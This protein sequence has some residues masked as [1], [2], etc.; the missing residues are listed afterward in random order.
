MFT[1]DPIP[2]KMIHMD[3][4]ILK[5]IVAAVLLSVTAGVVNAAASDDHVVFDSLTMVSKEYTASLTRL[6]GATFPELKIEI[7]WCKDPSSDDPNSETTVYLPNYFAQVPFQSGGFSFDQQP[8]VVQAKRMTGTWNATDSTVTF[9]LPW[10]IGR[11]SFGSGHTFSYESWYCLVP[12]KT[13]YT[14]VARLIWDS[15]ELIFHVD[16]SGMWSWDMNIPAGNG[17]TTDTEACYAL[18]VGIMTEGYQ[19]QRGH[20]VEYYWK[21]CPDA[22]TSLSFTPVI[23][24]IDDSGFHGQEET[25]TGSWYD[26]MGREVKNPVKGVFI[27]NGKKVAF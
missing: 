26:L 1:L 19:E 5:K 24:G 17:E 9:H 27:R 11:E 25:I 6:S 8:S 3:F 4:S 2:Q 14:D 12:A 18:G 7:W 23:S 21:P 13:L 10:K 20:Y 22:I 15:W 16:E